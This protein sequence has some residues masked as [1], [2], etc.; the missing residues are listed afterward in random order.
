MWSNPAAP[1]GEGCLT[2]ALGALQSQGLQAELM[3]T[4]SQQQ[5]GK[6][7]AASLLQHCETPQGKHHLGVFC[8]GGEERER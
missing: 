3:G 4:A 6:G 2:G 1:A 5:A 7:T 8:K